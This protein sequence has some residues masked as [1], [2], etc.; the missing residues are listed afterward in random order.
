M[1]TVNRDN[2]HTF[3]SNVSPSSSNPVVVVSDSNQ[4]NAVFKK[5]KKSKHKHTNII[6]SILTLIFV[7]HSSTYSSYVSNPQLFDSDGKKGLIM[8]SIA[9][10]SLYIPAT[11]A[12]S[13]VSIYNIIKKPKCE[14]SNIAH[15]VKSVLMCVLVVFE[16][17]KL[18]VLS[19]GHS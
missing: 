12:L 2:L 14:I 1:V 4:S 6:V 17:L 5:N 16:S 7:V 18:G 13:C 10:I 15:I 3:V 8:T 11:I 19:K 9:S